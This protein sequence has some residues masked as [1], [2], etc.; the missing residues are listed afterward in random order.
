PPLGDVSSRHMGSLS[1]CASSV[2]HKALEIVTRHEA[3]DFVPRPLSS[4][5]FGV[6][7]AMRVDTADTRTHN[8]GQHRRNLGRMELVDW[9]PRDQLLY[10]ERLRER[11]ITLKS[12][13]DYLNTQ[14]SYLIAIKALCSRIC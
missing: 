11:Y 6:T 8:A 14:T 12:K 1:G 4:E 2:T 10:P 3:D 13:V 7:A 5:I 9:K